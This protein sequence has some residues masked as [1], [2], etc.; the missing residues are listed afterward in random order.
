VIKRFTLLWIFCNILSSYFA[1]NSSF[2]LF[3]HDILTT[4]QFAS[5]LLGCY[6]YSSPSNTKGCRSINKQFSLDS[7]LDWEGRHWVF[8]HA[9]IWRTNT[10]SFMKDLTKTIVF[11]WG[12]ILTSQIS[13]TLIHF[14]NQV[15]LKYLLII[16]IDLQKSLF[17]SLSCQLYFESQSLHL[18]SEIHVDRYFLMVNPY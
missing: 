2:S 8:K 5:D 12:F 18:V 14:F 17:C 11:F 7:F 6:S 1:N 4:I 3:L 13:S 15:P 16:K 9:L 10:L